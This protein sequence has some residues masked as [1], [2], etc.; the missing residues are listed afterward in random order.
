MHFDNNISNYKMYSNNYNYYNECKFTDKF[1][2]FRRILRRTH[3][4]LTGV[5]NAVNAVASPFGVSE[6]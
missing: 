4:A 1:D 2:I 3:N 6:L 5:Q